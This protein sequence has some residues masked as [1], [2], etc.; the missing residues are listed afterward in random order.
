MSF[1]S[2]VLVLMHVDVH[3]VLLRTRFPGSLY[4]QHFI[5][6]LQ[7]NRDENLVNSNMSLELEKSPF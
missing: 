7:G 6:C 2:L 4:S 3:S 1:V 5:P